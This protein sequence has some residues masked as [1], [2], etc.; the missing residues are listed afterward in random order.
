MIFIANS[1]LSAQSVFQNIKGRIID[2]QSQSPLAGATVKVINS[3]LGAVT[4]EGGYFKI[5][6]VPVGRVS[7]GVSY[8]GYKPLP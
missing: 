7:L 8:L 4:D 6:H 5:E 1:F 3:P 2:K